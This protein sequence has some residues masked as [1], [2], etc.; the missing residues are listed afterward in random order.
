MRIGSEWRH[1]WLTCLRETQGAPRR[2]GVRDGDLRQLVQEREDGQGWRCLREDGRAARHIREDILQGWCSLNYQ[3]LSASVHCQLM[4]LPLLC[5]P[6]Y[7]V[8]CILRYMTETTHEKWTAP[9]NPWRSHQ[10]A[11]VL[12]ATCPDRR[13]PSEPAPPFN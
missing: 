10:C 7:I 3:R 5:L 1:S 13:L 4:R 6:F 11:S 8:L 9:A 12:D 2:G